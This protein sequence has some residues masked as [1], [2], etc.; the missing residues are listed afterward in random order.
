MRLSEATGLMIDD[1]K[2][3]STLPYIN[4]IPHAHRRLKTASSQRKIPLAGLSLWAAK[5]LKQ[6]STSLFCFP[7]YNTS[8]RGNSNS[9]SAALNKWI[10][11]IAGSNDVIH[12]L[13]HSFR[14]RLRA[15]EAPTDMIDQL[16]GWALKSVGQGYG[17]GYDLE[18]LVKYL[19][20]LSDI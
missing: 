15:V 2:L 8:D 13:R 3:E 20:K 14:D 6:H 19:S 16:G 7:R 17:D 5:G 18:L 12:G 1:L 9:A 4:L 11:T 10:K